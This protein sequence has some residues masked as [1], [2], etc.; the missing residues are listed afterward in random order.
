MHTFKLLLV[1]DSEEVLNSLLGASNFN[2]QNFC[3]SQLVD[4]LVY[5]SQRTSF[6]ED[7]EA[8]LEESFGKP[9]DFLDQLRFFY[10]SAFVLMLELFNR[11]QSNPVAVD[12]G[13]NEVAKELDALLSLGRLLEQ[14]LFS[15]F[16]Q[17]DSSKF[18]HFVKSYC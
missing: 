6:L 1:F 13:Q 11:S 16:F 12:E 2:L 7:K 18:L 9:L 10:K 14:N 15:L 17:S 8:F 5:D 4:S 3:L